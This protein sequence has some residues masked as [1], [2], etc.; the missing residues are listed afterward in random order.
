MTVTQRLKEI[1]HATNAGSVCP[2]A[3]D[4]LFLSVVSQYLCKTK[5]HN[6]MSDS[7][8]DQLCKP[9]T[10]NNRYQYPCKKKTWWNLATEDRSI[11][12]CPHGNCSKNFTME[13]F[14]EHSKHLCAQEESVSDSIN[15]DEIKTGLQILLINEIV[16]RSQIE[17][18]FVQ[19]LRKS[20]F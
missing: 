7:T 2:Q 12:R 15:K 18:F 9:C 6:R 4:N 11:F 16:K 10:Y 19:K 20:C 14:F 3:F 17:F 8:S 13:E 5:Y 1:F